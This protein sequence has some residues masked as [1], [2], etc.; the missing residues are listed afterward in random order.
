MIQSSA[1]NLDVAQVSSIVRARSGD[2]VVLG[3]LIQTQDSTTERGVPGLT[4]LGPVSRLFGGRYENRVRKE[5]IMVLTPTIV[6][7]ED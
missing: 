1:P 5:L 6:A 4:K 3:G 7:A 2:T